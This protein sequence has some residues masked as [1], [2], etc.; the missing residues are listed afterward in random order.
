MLKVDNVNVSIK[1][2][3]ILEGLTLHIDYGEVAGLVAP[4]GYG[5]TTLL[6]T[7]AG[8]TKIVSGDVFVEDVSLTKHSPF[9]NKNLFFFQNV[10]S[11]YL[12]LTV[13][14]HLEFVKKSWQS[15][16]NIDFVIQTLKMESYKNKKV[17][18]LSLGMKQH[19][20]I[21][22][23]IISEASLIL[24]DEPFNG[25]DPSSVKIV[26]H[27]I[28][29]MANEKKSFLFSSHILSHIDLI[30]SK[31]LFL[32]DKKIILVEDLLHQKFTNTEK[33]Y[34]LLYEEISL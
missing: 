15:S 19:L 3:C 22:M 5:K 18:Q 29:Q 32:K 13:L 24:M 14:E 26:S 28:K 30:C 20:L 31:V 27:I 7:I 17:K 34:N 4:N 12:N 25:L 23:A 6:K 33:N 11:L 21:A 10:E 9:Y 2:T 8:L 16:K 1:K